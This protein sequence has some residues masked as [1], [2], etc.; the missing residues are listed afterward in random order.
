MWFCVNMPSAASSQVSKA[1]EEFEGL[2][3]EEDYE[4]RLM[5]TP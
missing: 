3:P 4:V 1:E 2:L 5:H